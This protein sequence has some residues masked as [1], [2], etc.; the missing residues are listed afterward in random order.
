MQPKKNNNIKYYYTNEHNIEEKYAYSDVTKEWLN[1]STPNKGNIIIDNYF[2]SDDGIRH[3]IKNQEKVAIVYK[4]SSEYKM[5][6]ILKILF[7]GNIHLIPRIEQEKGYKGVVKVPTPDFRWNGKK[8]DLKTP[9][10]NGNFNNTIERFLKKKN[11]KKQA[12]RFIINYI[13][14][15]YKNDEEILKIVE[16][17][18]YNRNWVEELI[19]LRGEKIIKIYSKKKIKDSSSSTMPGGESQM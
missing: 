5:A 14:F 16:K 2:I 10:S 19:I 4:N 8:W 12:K 9:S 17:T 1:N 6:E 11:A 7:G 15:P 18:L 13:N 3:P